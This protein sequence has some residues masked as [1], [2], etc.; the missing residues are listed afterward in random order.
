MHSCDGSRFG[1]ES[2]NFFE[3]E[4]L[5]RGGEAEKRGREI[6]GKGK[7]EGEGRRSNLPLGCHLY[8]TE[9]E[10]FVFSLFT[11]LVLQ[12]ESFSLKRK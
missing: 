6:E 2:W 12:R 8:F 9:S 11:Q 5:R 1:W 4:F 3:R 10:S 7:G